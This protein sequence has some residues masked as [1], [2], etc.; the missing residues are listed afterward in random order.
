MK[1]L[2]FLPIFFLTM[3]NHCLADEQ[4]CFEEHFNLLCKSTIEFDKAIDLHV[5]FA[6][7]WLNG[8]L[9]EANLRLEKAFSEFFNENE[10]G[11]LSS[12]YEMTPELAGSSKV[13]W[14]IRTWLRIYYLFQPRLSPENKERLESLFWNY[15]CAKSTIAR[16]KLEYIWCIQGSENH[17]MMDLSNA[18]L[19]VQA[20]KDHPEYVSRTLLDGHLAHEHCRAWTRYYKEF[21]TTR[22]QNGLF[23]EV[24]S[25]TYGKYFLPELVNMSDFSEDPDLRKKMT[26]LL[27]LIWADWAIDQLNGIRGGAKTRAYLNHYS[28]RGISDSWYHIAQVVFDQQDWWNGAKISNHAIHGFPFI[29]GS[30]NYRVPEVIQKLALNPDQRDEYEYISLRPGRLTD[31]PVE[32][33]DIPK[34]TYQMDEEIPGLIRYS[35]CTPDYITGSFMDYPS[36]DDYAAISTQNRWQGIVFPTDVN[37]RIFPQCEGLNKGKNYQQFQSVQYKNVMLVKR[38]P[39]GK[40]VGTMKVFFSEG[41]KERLQEVDGRYYIQEGDAF[42]AVVPI[43]ATK[44]FESANTIWENQLW[45]RIDEEPSV[46]VFVTGRKPHF[47]NIDAFLDKISKHEVDSDGKDFTYRYPEVDGEWTVLS[48]PMDRPALPKINGSH[49]DLSPPQTFK[50]PYLYSEGRTGTVTVRF[51]D[52]SL[53][54][55]Q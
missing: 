36:L 7:F 51:N 46:V 3:M 54:I 38:N 9:E 15:A 35:Y 19:S 44:P 10:S 17:D 24:N 39:Y 18:F 20:I 32:T 5:A 16:T 33:D 13:K 34:D 40:G 52:T 2:L 50:S 45:L 6:Q 29:L 49:I 22:A 23:A 27:H 48:L 12:Q 30:S 14:Q 28:Y 55:E 47:E 8:D 11:D 1:I 25:P 43:S 21:C 31:T 37:A 53:T 4:G 41:I 26:S 42:A